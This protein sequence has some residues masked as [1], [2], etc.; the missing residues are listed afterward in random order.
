MIKIDKHEQVLKAIAESGGR[1]TAAQVA[2]ESK[3]S[4]DTAIARLRELVSLT[5]R[6][7]TWEAE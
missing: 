7:L 4:R 1:A 2:A 5:F 6:R 3:I